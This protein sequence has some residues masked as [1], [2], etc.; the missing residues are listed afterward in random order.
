MPL[1]TMPTITVQN[2]LVYSWGE[3]CDATG[4]SDRS[5]AEGIHSGRLVGY[6]V[7]KK[8][9]FL[10]DDVYAWIRTHP[11]YTKYVGPGSE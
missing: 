7:D 2:T 3:L 4:L 8:C 10:A 1:V 5:I 6:E 11:H 9:L